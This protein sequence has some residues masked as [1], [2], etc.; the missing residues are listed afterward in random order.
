MKLHYELTHSITQHINAEAQTRKQQHKKAKWT[1]SPVNMTLILKF[2]ILHRF[3]EPYHCWLRPQILNARKVGDQVV[4]GVPGFPQLREARLL[5]SS[6][7]STGHR[8]QV[9]VASLRG[10]QF[11]CLSVR[12]WRNWHPLNDP[13][14]SGIASPKRISR[15][16]RDSRLTTHRTNCCWSS[17]NRMNLTSTIT[18]PNMSGQTEGPDFES[19]N[20]SVSGW[21]PGWFSLDINFCPIL[22]APPDWGSLCSPR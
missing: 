22:A 5:H 17:T 10:L 21:R 9:P 19:A 12:D 18:L 11:A 16:F 7:G 13:E 4:I 15:T 3:L 2:C 1:A 20:V 14:N 6:V 8:Q